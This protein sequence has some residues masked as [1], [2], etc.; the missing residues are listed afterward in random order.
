[1]DKPLY[2]WKFSGR[3]LRELRES[4]GLTRKSLA[5]RIGKTGTT[6]YNWECGFTLPGCNDLPQ[7]LGAFGLSLSLAARLYEC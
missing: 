1:M 3:K 7:L 5:E 6:V 4:A 2:T